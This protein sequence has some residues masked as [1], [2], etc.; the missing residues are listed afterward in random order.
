MFAPLTTDE[1]AAASEAA[2]TGAPAPKDGGMVIWE[3]LLPVP[4]DAPRAIPPHRLGKPSAKWAYRDANGDLLGMVCR[5]DRGDGGKDVVPLVFARNTATGE[6]AWRWQA[7][8]TPRPLYGLDRLAAHPDAPVLVVEGEKAADAAAPL[9]PGH[10]AVT[11][12]GGSKAADK[13]D[14]SALA[15]RRVVIWGD[16]DP[17]GRSYAEAVARLALAAGAPSI[18]MVQVPAGWPTAWDLADKPPPGVMADDLRDLL[19]NAVPFD[20]TG[21]AKPGNGAAPDPESISARAW[22]ERSIEPTEWLLGPFAKTTRAMLSAPS[23]VG[24]TNF[25][26]ALA[27]HLAAGLDF[28]HWTAHR[29]A[30]VLYIDG[31]MPCELI[32]QRVRDAER[33]LGRPVEGLYVLAKDAEPDMP[34]LNTPEGQVFADRWIEAVNP[35]F[36]VFD[37]VMSL[38]TGEMSDETGWQAIK[39]WIAALT[40]RRI[41]QLWVHHTGHDGSRPFGTSTRIWNFDASILLTPLKGDDDV[42]FSLE[43]QKARRRTP[44]TRDDYGTITVALAD[45]KWTAS[46]AGSRTGGAPVRG[47]SPSPTAQRYYDALVNAIASA[48]G[49]DRRVGPGGTPATTNKAWRRE[50]IR[51]GLIGE[52]AEPRQQRALFYKYRPQLVTAKWIAMNG[53]TVWSLRV[54]H[55]E[56]PSSNHSPSTE[57]NHRATVSNPLS[58][59]GATMSNHSSAPDSNHEQPSSIGDG[60]SVARLLDA[61]EGTDTAPPEPDDDAEFF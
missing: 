56:Q 46:T 9:F 16:N 40:N 28:L 11:S 54:P 59:C 8:P 10:I 23:G 14:W 19:E 39:P 20:A 13:A 53:E 26:L 25:A 17:P 1:M 50:L 45:D 57:S 30:R 34:P 49:D 3:P 42:A 52:D 58:N 55:P 51:M 12:P 15:G 31:E 29:P 33:R 22:G 44:D 61:D 43:F 21:S 41:G 32:Q 7:F 36:I 4:D 48:T 47:K 35:D 60:C 37:N 6:T 38:L 18:A 24:K 27:A 5:F 2:A